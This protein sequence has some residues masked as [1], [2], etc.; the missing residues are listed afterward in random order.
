MAPRIT[1]SNQ[2]DESCL[3]IGLDFPAGIV[4]E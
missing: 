3:G 1:S 2:A 4:V